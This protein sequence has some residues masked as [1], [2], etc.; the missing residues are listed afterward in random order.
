MLP[1]LK[2]LRFSHCLLIFRESLLFE[3]LRVSLLSS[4]HILA[5]KMDVFSG[6]NLEEFCDEGWWGGIWNG[7]RHM[8][9]WTSNGFLSS[10]S[11]SH[12]GYDTHQHLES[13]Q[14]Y[15]RYLQ[16]S[17]RLWSSSGCFLSQFAQLS[18]HK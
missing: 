2:Q 9:H 4:C 16:K 18:E 13:I 6:L 14:W 1:K 12:W 5:W 10:L 7:G 3:F 15:V 11:T 8:C 17:I